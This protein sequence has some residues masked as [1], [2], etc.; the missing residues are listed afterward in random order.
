MVHL[1]VTKSLGQR[2]KAAVASWRQDSP[3]RGFLPG[4]MVPAACSSCFREDSWREDSAGDDEEKEEPRAC[5]ASTSSTLKREKWS[6]FLVTTRS[7]FGGRHRRYHGVP[8]IHRPPP[9]GEGGKLLPRPFGRLPVEGEY[10]EPLE[11]P[12]DLLYVLAPL[13]RPVGQ[14]EELEGVDGGR[15]VPPLRVQLLQLP[16]RLGV[17]P[18]D[19]Y[20]EVTVE[21]FHV[22]PSP[23]LRATPWRARQLSWQPLR[24]R[25]PTHRSARR[26]SP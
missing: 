5:Q 23:A 25:R 21:G 12:L 22:R 1:D 15:G 8:E 18:E 14:V 24:Q 17:A 26:A 6:A 9:S 4:G 7:P 19:G 10:V 11:E 16:S 2:P 13:P 20:Q 3:C